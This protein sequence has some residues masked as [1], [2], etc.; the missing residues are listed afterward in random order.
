MLDFDIDNTKRE[1]EHHFNH[2]SGLLGPVR[3]LPDMI[4]FWTY[5]FSVKFYVPFKIYS[6][7]GSSD[8]F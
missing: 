6:F 8:M 1:P 2:H 3:L 4:I 5:G 7:L